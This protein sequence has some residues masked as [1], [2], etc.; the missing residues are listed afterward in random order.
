M[1][2]NHLT[3]SKLTNNLDSKNS[4]GFSSPR[5]SVDAWILILHI[6]TKSRSFCIQS[7]IHDMT[8]FRSLTMPPFL[9]I[10][11]LRRQLNWNPLPSQY[12]LRSQDF[13]FFLLKR[14]VKKSLRSLSLLGSYTLFNRYVASFVSASDELC[15]HSFFHWSIVWSVNVFLAGMLYLHCVFD[16]KWILL[17]LFLKIAYA[18]NTERYKSKRHRTCIW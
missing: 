9:S 15:T 18:L 1:S 10:A 16:T 17:V 11:G 7:L 13:L 14:F 8:D 3:Y 4:W 6:S 5:K 12:F 2:L